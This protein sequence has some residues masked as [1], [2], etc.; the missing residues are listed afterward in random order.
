MVTAGFEVLDLILGIA[1]LVT[2]AKAAII[3]FVVGELLGLPSPCVDAFQEWGGQKFKGRAGALKFLEFLV[4]VSGIVV[5]ATNNDPDPDGAAATLRQESLMT[6]LAGVFLSMAQL[7]QIAKR[8]KPAVF[9]LIVGVI[10]ILITWVF[11]KMSHGYWHTNTPDNI[12]VPFNLF[13][14]GCTAG[15]FAISAGD[16]SG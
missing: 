12:L 4:A 15:F 14:W 7:T 3:A 2:G 8:P 5:I 10:V 11:I 13:L 1:V 16:E 6:G 9:I